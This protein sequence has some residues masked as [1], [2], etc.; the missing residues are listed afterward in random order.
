MWVW[1]SLIAA[2][3]SS[4]ING[5]IDGI[6]E[7]LPAPIPHGRKWN[8]VSEEWNTCSTRLERPEPLAGWLC[9]S[10]PFSVPNF[11]SRKR[12]ER[13]SE[14]IPAILAQEFDKLPLQ[15]EMTLG[16]KESLVMCALE[17]SLFL[18]GLSNMVQ[19]GKVSNLQAKLIIQP[20]KL[21]YRGS[22]V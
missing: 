10:D 18:R 17:K 13:A 1:F 22:L 2:A 11:L 4:R 7:V 3:P 9:P 20:A 12:K 19:D 5:V 16:R 8:T 14:R 6:D 15:G 21:V